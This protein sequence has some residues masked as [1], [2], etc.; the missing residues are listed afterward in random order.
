M[1]LGALTLAA[2]AASLAAAA[3][4]AD[5]T[6]FVD[7]TYGAGSV[8]GEITTDG[9]IGKLSDSNFLSWNLV[10]TDGSNL[11]FDLN[12]LDSSVLTQPDQDVSGTANL[13]QF[14][15]GGAGGFLAFFDNNPTPYGSGVCWSTT[16][17]GGC[18]VPGDTTGGA[19]IIDLSDTSTAQ[20]AP[21]SGTAY[22]VGV[23]PTPEPAA[24]ALMLVGFAGLGVALRTRRRAAVTA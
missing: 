7:H 20:I 8:T 22:V 13:L 15:F 14:N 5:I 10:I 21:L 3:A 12:P 24:W 23:L 4:H 17:V 1:R 19:S 6:Y 11:P 9:T 16:G 18:V 2:A